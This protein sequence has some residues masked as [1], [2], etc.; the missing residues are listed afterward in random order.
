VEAIQIQKNNWNILIQFNTVP[1]EVL[2]DKVTD[3]GL[4]RLM[5]VEHPGKTLE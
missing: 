1:R 2:R 4:T 5:E 3:V